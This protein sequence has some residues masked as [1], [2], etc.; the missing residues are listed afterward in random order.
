MSTAFKDTGHFLG[1][2]KT[3]F[4]T[5]CI[6]GGR[7]VSQHTHKSLILLNQQ[8]CEHLGSIGNRIS[9]RKMKHNLCT[10]CVLHQM[11][12]INKSLFWERNYLFLKNYVPSER[13]VSHNVSNYLQ[14]SIARYQVQFDANNY[15]EQLPLV[16]SAFK[17]FGYFFKTSTDLQSTYC[18]W[19]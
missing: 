1:L 5:W 6:H 17:G 9:K 12:N 11:P 13:A 3:S 2:S 19:R 14:L 4:L 8:T 16:S 18:V 10:K 15:F 7:S